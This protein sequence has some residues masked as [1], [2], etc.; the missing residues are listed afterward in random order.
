M[1]GRSERA[2]ASTEEENALNAV[3]DVDVVALEANDEV[4]V[5][6]ELKRRTARPV[7]TARP[8]PC[9]SL[10][11]ADGWWWPA[12]RGPAG[13]ALA[14]GSA[15]PRGTTSASSRSTARC[16]VAVASGPLP[17]RSRRANSCVRSHRVDHEP[18]RRPT[19]AGCRR[20]GRAKGQG[21]GDVAVA[22]RRTR[23]CRRDR[24]RPARGQSPAAV[25]VQVSRRRRSGSDW[26]RRGTDGGD[27]PR[28][29]RQHPL[30]RTG[31]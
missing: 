8:A 5:M 16:R 28:R 29:C 7:Q 23:K 19:C 24:P 11:A 20:R 12:L 18:L 31:R 26:V 27:R 30:R 6:L 17:T 22:L 14:A 2:R 13:A 3:V 4:W 10:T 1:R 9:R 25:G 21:G 15:R